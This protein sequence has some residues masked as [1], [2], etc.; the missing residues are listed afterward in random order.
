MHYDTV[1][2]KFDECSG[3]APFVDVVTDVAG[4]LVE[5]PML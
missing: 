5:P 2:V 1:R 4:D 3:K